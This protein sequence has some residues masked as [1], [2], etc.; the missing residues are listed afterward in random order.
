MHFMIVKKSRKRSGFVIY[1]YLKNNAFTA[2]TEGCKVLNQLC[3]GLLIL[4]R[5][6][7]VYETGTF[8]VKNA[9]YQLTVFDGTLT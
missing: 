9:A 7:S 1:S 3:E 4:N 2:V 8:S 6:S 5:R